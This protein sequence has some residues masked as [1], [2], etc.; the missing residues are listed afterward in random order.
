MRYAAF[1][2]LLLSGCTLVPIA[3]AGPCVAVS[4]A[5]GC[6]YNPYV[7]REPAETAAATQG[8]SSQKAGAAR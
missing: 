1:L 7:I 2:L 4:N 6:Q 3:D 8:D 5:R